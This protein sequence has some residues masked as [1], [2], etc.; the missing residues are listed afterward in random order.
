VKVVGS[1]QAVQISFRRRLR[2]STS[3]SPTPSEAPTSARAPSAAVMLGAALLVGPGTGVAG[4]GRAGGAATQSAAGAA[5]DRRC[6]AATGPCDGAGAGRPRGD[7]DGDAEEE[8]EDGEDG[9]SCSAGMPSMQSSS[10]S[11]AS[12]A[13]GIVRMRAI[14][15][16]AGG[17]AA[18]A[19]YFKEEGGGAGLGCKHLIAITRGD[20]WIASGR[21]TQSTSAG[22]LARRP[23]A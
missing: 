21:P 1:S 18:F 16:T 15:A 2:G 17:L 8:E 12:P 14:M 7:D 20:N 13:A 19:A 5:C 4:R 10:A 23:D 9:A 22:Q 11:S 6:A 3:A